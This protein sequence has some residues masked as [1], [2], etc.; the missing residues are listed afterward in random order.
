MT[1]RTAEDR[2]L[3]ELAKEQP[4]GLT[5][6]ELEGRLMDVRIPE[7]RRAMNRLGDKIIRSH[8]HTQ[9][10]DLRPYTITRLMLPADTVVDVPADKP[11]PKAKKPG[12]KPKA[13][14]VSSGNGTVDEAY[15]WFANLVGGVPGPCPTCEGTG[16]AEIPL[17]KTDVTEGLNLPA[18][19]HLPKRD[20]DRLTLKALRSMQTMLGEGATLEQAADVW[21]E[22]IARSGR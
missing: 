6:G 22:L 12:P 5:E 20:P 9:D 8:E 3:E 4:D 21:L 17:S 1:A 19:T 11:K 2:I 18:L 15:E 16:T 14:R 13:K 10:A 7:L